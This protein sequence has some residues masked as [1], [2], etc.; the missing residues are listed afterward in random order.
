MSLQMVTA[1][2]TAISLPEPVS[3]KTQMTET[4][5]LFM[6]FQASATPSHG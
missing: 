2:L 3:P 1:E 5:G 4:K 6:F